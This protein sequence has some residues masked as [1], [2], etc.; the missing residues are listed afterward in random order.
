MPWGPIVSSFSRYTRNASG[1]HAWAAAA[2]SATPSLAANGTGSPALDQTRVYSVRNGKIVVAENL[3][4]KFEAPPLTAGWI[5]SGAA[6]AAAER[7]AI[8]ELRREHDAR[9]STMLLV[10]G[11]MAEGDPDATTW[12]LVYTSP[13]APS[14]FVVVDATDGKVRR[15]WRG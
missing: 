6:A 2:L 14:L 12:L 8:H 1:A 7:T 3:D 5:D 10:R 15:T 4:M 11:P 13:G 9:L